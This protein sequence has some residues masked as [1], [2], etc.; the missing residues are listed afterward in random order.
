MF[1][2]IAGGA[3]VLYCEALLGVMS[4]AESLDRRRAGLYAALTGAVVGAV[5]WLAP[6][7]V[8][9]GDAITQNTLLG[10]QPLAALLFVFFFRFGFGA[11][12]YATATPGEYSRQCSFW[13]RSSG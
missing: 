13:A 4:L 2:A 6:D 8:G 5:A 7:L 3:A 12:S 1:G 9:G 11:V 10:T